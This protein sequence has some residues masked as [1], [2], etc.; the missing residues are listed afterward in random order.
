MPVAHE[1][2]Q[3]VNA[4]LRRS[5]L[6]AKFL[7]RGGAFFGAGCVALGNLVHLSDGNIDL[8]DSLG[9]LLRSAGYVCHESIY[10]PYF[11]DNVVEPPAHPESEF[12]PLR[13]F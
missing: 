4:Q 7:G 13:A 12:D 8:G 2:K 1:Y 10:L 11:F 6:S 9:L 3:F 5:G